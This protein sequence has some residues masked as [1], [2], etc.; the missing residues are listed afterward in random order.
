MGLL[1]AV[2]VATGANAAMDVTY[3]WRCGWV[4]IAAKKAV[5]PI[6]CPKSKNSEIYYNPTNI[7]KRLVV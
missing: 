4:D 7:S 3:F 6:E 1:I 5:D 2:T